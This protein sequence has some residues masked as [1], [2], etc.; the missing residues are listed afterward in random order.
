MSIASYERVIDEIMESYSENPSGWKYL[1]S[2]NPEGRGYDI[3]VY[4]PRV[5][6]WQIKI[7][8]IYSYPRGLGKKLEEPEKVIDVL[9]AKGRFGL[10]PI[11]PR[12]FF[13]LMVALESGNRDYFEKYMEELTER[14]AM[15]PKEIKTPVASIGP[16]DFIPKPSPLGMISEEQRELEK[17]LSKELEKLY[18]PHYLG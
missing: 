8:S 5:G 7:E 4:N 9:G 14:P 11:S 3:V 16:F 2:K 17:R 1:A 15:S 6:M 13:V 12:D 10:R 18:G